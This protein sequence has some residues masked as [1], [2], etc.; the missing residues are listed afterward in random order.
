MNLLMVAVGLLLFVAVMVIGT[1]W[2][3]YDLKRHQARQTMPG[4]R[5]DLDYGDL[6]EVVPAKVLAAA[7]EQFLAYFRAHPEVTDFTTGAIRIKKRGSCSFRL[8]LA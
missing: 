2:D 7:E 6:W 4:G 1:V 8:G 5:L 3:K